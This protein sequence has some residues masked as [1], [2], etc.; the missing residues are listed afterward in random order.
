[1]LPQYKLC[2]FED[3]VIIN[4]LEGHAR[5]VVEL[6]NGLKIYQD[7]FRQYEEFKDELYYSTWSRLRHYCYSERIDIVGMY[8]QFRTNRHNLAQNADGYY[9]CKSI[10]AAF[11]MPENHHFFVTG[12]VKMIR[13]RLRF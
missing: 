11:G 13:K 8:L 6:S 1:M 7:D 2:E 12:V 9:F 10:L 5:W 4:N 3:E